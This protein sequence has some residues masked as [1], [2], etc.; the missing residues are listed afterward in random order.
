MITNTNMETNGLKSSRRHIGLLGTPEQGPSSSHSS[1][2]SGFIIGGTPV[3]ICCGC[4]LQ[5]APSQ[6]MGTEVCT[7]ISALPEEHP[8]LITSENQGFQKNNVFLN[9]QYWISG[10]FW[11]LL[12]LLLM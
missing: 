10:T 5:V 1:G 9:F 7:G 3:P 4:I 2:P 11:I 8:C 6:E 12:G